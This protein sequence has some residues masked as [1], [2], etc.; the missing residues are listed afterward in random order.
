MLQDKRQC[1][2][3]YCNRFKS[4][5]ESGKIST[6]KSPEDFI[7]TGGDNVD[8]SL[9]GLQNDSKV[10]DMPDTNLIVPT[11]YQAEVRCIDRR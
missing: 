9:D 3:L 5:N 6:R 1:F 7:N 8:S 11:R 2:P 10:A 4:G